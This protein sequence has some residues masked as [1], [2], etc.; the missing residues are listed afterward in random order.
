MCF[1]SL[2]V[3]ILKDVKSEE[4]FDHKIFHVSEEGLMQ[5]GRKWILESDEPEFK[6]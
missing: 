2:P 6:S 4:Y 3:D 5:L 1:N